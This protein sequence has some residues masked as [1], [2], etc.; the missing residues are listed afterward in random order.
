MGSSQSDPRDSP[1]ACVKQNLKPLLLID[2]K[3][4]KLES[5]CTQI[6]PQYKLDDQNHWPEFRTFDFN[7]LSDL[8]N[9]LTQNGKWSEVPYIQA[10]RDLRSCPSLCKDCFTYQSSSALSPPPLQKNPNL[11]PLKGPLTPQPL[12]L[13]WQMSLLPI[14]LERKLPEVRPYPLALPPPKQKVMTPKPQKR[15]PPAVHQPGSKTNTFPL[16]EVAGPEGPTWVHVPFSISDMSQ[17][18]KN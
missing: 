14:A 2:L 16:R 13:T 1:L 8:T 17:L 9:F 3:V 6:W 10:F 15:F 18:K 12:I 11:K 7:I 4:H 5:L